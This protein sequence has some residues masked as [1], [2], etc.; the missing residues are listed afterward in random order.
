MLPQFLEQLLAPP[1]ESVRIL[2]EY[3]RGRAAVIHQKITQG[4]AWRGRSQT[5]IQAFYTSDGRHSEED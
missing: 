2:E 1:N 3:Y 4:V 5:I